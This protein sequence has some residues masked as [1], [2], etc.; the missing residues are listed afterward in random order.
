[1][2]L[3]DDDTISDYLHKYKSQF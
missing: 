2:D 1:M 3:T